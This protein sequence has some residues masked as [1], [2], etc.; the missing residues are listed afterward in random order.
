M[1]VSG[2]A[3]M[4]LSQ[5]ALIPTQSFEAEQEAATRPQSAYSGT[6]FAASFSGALLG[7][8]IPGVALAAGLMA[9]GPHP[10]ASCSIGF[11]VAIVAAPTLATLGAWAGHRLA[12]GRGTFLR[13]VFSMAVATTLGAGVGWLVQQAS[14]NRLLQLEVLAPVV[15][16][17][18]LAGFVF[19]AAMLEWSNKLESSSVSLG[20]AP[21]PSG[22]MLGFSARF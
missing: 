14:P 4:L 21:L 20:L 18:M 2:F 11:A 15:A 3:V 22:A 13:S 6:R 10:D 8:A 5:G 17:S 19:T 7:A 12:G 16:A 1:F 9:C